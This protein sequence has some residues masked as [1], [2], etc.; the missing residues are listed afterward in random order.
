MEIN[1]N[2]LARVK[3]FVGIEDFLNQ[4][5]PVAA[6]RASVLD[7]DQDF[8]EHACDAE[9]VYNHFRNEIELRISHFA[10]RGEGEPAPAG[11]DIHDYTAEAITLRKVN[12]ALQMHCAEVYDEIKNKITAKNQ[13][14][15]VTEVMAEISQQRKDSQERA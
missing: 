4:L 2:V 6:V 14:K 9:P 7:N 1:S 13:T 5:L 8:F 3:D 12:R 15:S 10:V 11:K